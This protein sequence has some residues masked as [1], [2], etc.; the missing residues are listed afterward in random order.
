MKPIGISLGTDRL[1]AMLPGGRRIDS[2]EVTDLRQAFAELK[3]VAGLARARVTI[4]LL[5]PLIDLR[6]VKLPPL[7]QEERRRVLARESGR[8][9]VGVREP[10]V[11]AS[12][13]SLAV[14]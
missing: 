4:A 9:F 11:I 5:P 8:Y 14:A 1:V 10:Q 3:K 2:T 6:R 12:D 13:A 7:R